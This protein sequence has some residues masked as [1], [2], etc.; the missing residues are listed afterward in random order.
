MCLPRGDC[1]SWLSRGDWTF[2]FSRGDCTFCFSR[3][4]CT[5]WFSR[6]DCTFCFPR[7]ELKG[8]LSVV[9]SG[10]TGR[11]VDALDPPCGGLW[12]GFWGGEFWLCARAGLTMRQLIPAMPTMRVI[13]MTCSFDLA[14]VVS[15]KSC[16]LVAG[17]ERGLHRVCHGSLQRSSFRVEKERRARRQGRR[18]SEVGHASRRSGIRDLARPSDRV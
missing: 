2:W 18:E 5:S 13:F 6:G 12:E 15:S 17:R 4:D 16:R 3:G 10:G 7:F 9:G 8:R 1:T 11:S 14:G